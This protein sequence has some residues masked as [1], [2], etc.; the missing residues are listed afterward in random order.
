MNYL[1]TTLHVNNL[2]KSLDFY[3][4]FLGL[5]LNKRY[6]AGPGMVLAFLGEGNTQIELVCAENTK[7]EGPG[8]GLSMGFQVESL[9]D[10]LTLVE[11][12]GIPV[13]R[14]ILQP[15]PHIRFFFVKDPDGYEIQFVEMIS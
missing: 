10:T 14:G 8:K 6:M 12:K 15:N 3:E 7:C 11:K 13:S 4:G 5:K 1:W 2:E 9:E